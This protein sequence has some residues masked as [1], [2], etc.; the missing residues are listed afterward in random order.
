MG[1]AAPTCGWTLASAAKSAGAKANFT[2]LWWDPEEPGWGLAV[3]HQGSTT[4]GTLFT[5]DNRNNPIWMVMSNGAQ[6]SSGAFGGP[7]YRASRRNIQQ[8]G[9]MSLTFDSADSGT[10]T[11][12][13]DGMEVQRRIVRMHF[14]PLVSSCGM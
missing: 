12:G 9:A 5:Y 14:A 7:L 8:A 2:S 13:M 1:D 3:S 10:V 6:K 4:F 11:Y